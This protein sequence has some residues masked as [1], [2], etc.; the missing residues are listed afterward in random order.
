MLNRKA[1][2]AHA[3]R[4]A[5]FPSIRS[6]SVVRRPDVEHFPATAIETSPQPAERSDLSDRVGKV[7]GLSLSLALATGA[8]ASIAHIWMNAGMIR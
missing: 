4:A 5:A 3:N 2:A 6:A 1:S 8:L 7:I